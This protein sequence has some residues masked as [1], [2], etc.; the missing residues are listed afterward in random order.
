M[1]DDDYANDNA[2]AGAGGNDTKAE[3]AMTSAPG[4][5]NPVWGGWGT[6]IWGLLIGVTFVA[7][8]TTFVTIYV[9]SITAGQDGGAARALYEQAISDGDVLSWATILSAVI[10]TFLIWVAVVSKR[11]SSTKDYLGLHPVDKKSVLLWTLLFIGLLIV[12]D[13]VTSLL[14]RPVTPDVMRE[15]YD[16][17]DSKVALFLATVVAASVFEELFFRGFLME[18]FKRTFLG[19][20]GSVILS[21]VLWSLVHVQYD[22]YGIVTIFAI[23]LFF[24]LAKLRS[25]STLFAMA[26]HA[27]NNAIAFFFLMLLSESG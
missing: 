16:T 15:I 17:S 13:L 21:A 20:W 3:A 8:Q 7:V 23:G 2:N 1:K 5:E 22:A 18:G 25:G 10:C 4:M 9:S 6:L 24:G 19:P 27:L 14:D 26:L 11:G 12:I